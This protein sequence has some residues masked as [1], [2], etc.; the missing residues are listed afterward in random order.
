V[1]DVASVGFVV[2]VAASLISF[3]FKLLV[4]GEGGGGPSTDK[5]D[6]FAA[7]V[8]WVEKGKA[9]QAV[10]ATVRPDNPDLPVDWSKTRTRPLCDWPRVARYQGA[11]DLES[12]GSFVCE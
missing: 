11:G 6:L 8:D 10:T 12:T 1:L 3:D 5:F 7:L 4:F 2:V 9:P